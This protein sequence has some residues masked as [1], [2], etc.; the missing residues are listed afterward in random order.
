MDKVV[1]DHTCSLPPTAADST[2]GIA[3]DAWTPVSELTP[4]SN[5]MIE[6]FSSLCANTKVVSLEERTRIELKTQNQSSQQEWHGVKS[7]RITGSISG[8]MLC[9]KKENYMW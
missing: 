9:Q 1:H 7:K 8:R 4:P 5:P 3:N 6:E 2:I